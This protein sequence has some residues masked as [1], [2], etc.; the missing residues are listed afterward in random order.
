MLPRS[1]NEFY[2]AALLSVSSVR[3]LRYSH[4]SCAFYSG[5]LFDIVSFLYVVELRE[6]LLKDISKLPSSS[7]DY[8]SLAFANGLIF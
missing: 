8:F 6:D 3:A 2:N 7:K 5:R 4:V 1:E